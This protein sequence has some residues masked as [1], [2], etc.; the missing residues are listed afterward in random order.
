ML[1][2]IKPQNDELVSNYGGYHTPATL[3][4]EL[5]M[6]EKQMPDDEAWRVIAEDLE[7]HKNLESQDKQKFQDEKQRLLNERQQLEAKAREAE[8][9]RTARDDALQ[10]KSLLESDLNIERNRRRLYEDALSP[11]LPNTY[12]PFNPTA[13]ASYIAKEKLKNQVKQEIVEEQKEARKWRN[14]ERTFKPKPKPRSKTRS[15]P[16][17]KSKS[18]P[19]PRSKSKSKKK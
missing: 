17:S 14:A 18:K 16:R 2:T 6:D 7:N 1:R 19:K 8:H 11:Y 12:D 13:V 15:K 5:G 10:K 9:L 3:R 4:Q